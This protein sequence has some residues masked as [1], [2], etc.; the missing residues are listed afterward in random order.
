[1]D[2]EVVDIRETERKFQAD[3]PPL[4]P[5]DMNMVTRAKT[6]LFSTAKELPK[7]NR[8]RDAP[9]WSVPA[10]LF[11]WCASPS[12]L[13]WDRGDWWKASVWKKSRNQ[14]RS[15]QVQK[16]ELAP[17]LVYLHHHAAHTA[18]TAP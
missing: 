13:S 5:L 3:M 17:V 4:E 16:K 12:Y 15:T 10:E 14:Q 7:R 1:M 2:A 8:R 18:Q 6:I 11:L 9:R